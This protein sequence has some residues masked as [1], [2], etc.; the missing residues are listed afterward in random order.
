MCI[1]DSLEKSLKNNFLDSISRGT[2]TKDKRKGESDKYTSW[3]VV[4]EEHGQQLLVYSHT[5]V[6]W[7]N[8]SSFKGIRRTCMV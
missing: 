6:N 7:E 2:E 1:R 5:Y 8:C 4:S 3:L